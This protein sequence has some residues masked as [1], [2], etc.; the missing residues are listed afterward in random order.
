MPR[1][2]FDNFS[3]QKVMIIYVYFYNE[4]DVKETLVILPLSKSFPGLPPRALLCNAIPD[5]IKYKK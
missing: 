4:A 3:I 2:Y 5:K 1:G